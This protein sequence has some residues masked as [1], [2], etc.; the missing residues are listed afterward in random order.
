MRR[1]PGSGK[2]SLGGA[3][4]NQGE[5]TDAEIR[6]SLLSSPRTH[7]VIV[8][9]PCG[10]FWTCGVFF[11]YGSRGF[12]RA[13]R[14]GRYRRSEMHYPAESTVLA[15]PKH[16]P[17]LPS[18]VPR[19]GL[20]E[21]KHPGR[22]DMVTASIQPSRPTVLIVDDQEWSARSLESV[23]EIHGYRVV[24][25]SSAHR[26]MKAAHK[27]PPDLLFISCT[28]PD[29]A[30][31]DLCRSVRQDRRFRA[32]LPIL[33]TALDTP[34]RSQRLDALRAGAWEF[35]AHP[36]DAE[37]LLLRLDLY[38]QARSRVTAKPRSTVGQPT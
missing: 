38:L 5:T 1:R 31:L 36:F 37:E 32:G 17:Q 21:R 12:S 35:L 20:S 27:H 23:L 29:D 33:F 25:A 2:R 3:P 9:V 18:R 7:V 13:R 28:L 4:S 34:T 19:K 22:P 6:A 14:A 10:S 30:G 24:R 26:A 11:C 16:V 15:A 8:Q